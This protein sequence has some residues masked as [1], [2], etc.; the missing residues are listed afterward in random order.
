MG[1]ITISLPDEL[2][3]T[4]HE[5]KLDWSDIAKR[6][7]IDKTEKLKRLKAF[8]SKFKLSN[9]DA[10]KLTDKIDNAVADRFLKEAK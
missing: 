9:K 8:S 4:M 3:K 2:E 1:T 7:L 6:A 5:F 10:K